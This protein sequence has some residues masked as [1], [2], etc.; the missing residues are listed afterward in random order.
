MQ[1]DAM[2]SSGASNALTHFLYMYHQCQPVY[3]GAS[4]YHLSRL[5]LSLMSCP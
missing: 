4:T 1:N 5:S 2:C 3:Y